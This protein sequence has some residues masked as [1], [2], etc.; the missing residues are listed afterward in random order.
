MPERDD[1]GDAQA[2]LPYQLETAVAG[3]MLA[4]SESEP[5]VVETPAG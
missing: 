4:G 5:R 2:T 1:S 3:T